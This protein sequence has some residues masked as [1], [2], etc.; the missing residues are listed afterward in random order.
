[1]D[2]FKNGFDLIL[3]EDNTKKSHLDFDKDNRDN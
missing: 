1:V 3:F 2:K